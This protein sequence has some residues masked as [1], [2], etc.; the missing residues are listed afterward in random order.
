MFDA[1]SGESGR[2]FCSLTNF[3]T[4]FD[5]EPFT[6]NDQYTIVTRRAFDRE[7]EDAYD[8]TVTCRDAGQPPLSGSATLQVRV[9]D[10]NDNFPTFDSSQY[11][12]TINENNRPGDVIV[13][14]H[15][16]DADDGI[17]AR[18]TYSIDDVIMRAFVVVDADSGDVTARNPL[19]R[20]A[21]SGLNFEV[22]ATDGGSPSRTTHTL[23]KVTIRDVNDE[24]PTFNQTTFAMSVAENEPALTPVGHVFARDLD[25]EPNAQFEY[26]LEVPVAWDV[27]RINRTSGL[28]QT[29][30]ELDREERAQ[31][32]L[33]VTARDLLDR[34]LVTSATVVIDVIDRN[35]NSPLMLFP[36][37]Q[38]RSVTV[39]SLLPVGGSVTRVEAID[40][41]DLDN[42]RLEF[43]FS[44]SVSQRARDVF[45]VD[46]V[47][48]EV[49][50]R[51]S[52][53]SFDGVAF[54]LEVE[55]I[56]H[57]SPRRSDT[58]ELIVTIDRNAP[59]TAPGNQPTDDVTSEASAD[60]SN[61]RAIVAVAVVSATIV[62]ALV[63]VIVVIKVRDQTPPCLAC[64]RRNDKPKKAIQSLAQAQR[65]KFDGVDNHVMTMETQHDPT[66][67][68]VR[69][70]CISNTVQHIHLEDLHVV[71]FL[72]ISGPGSDL[73]A[74]T[75]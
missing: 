13:R 14:V 63:V 20:E 5:L 57:G 60:V 22:S 27:F 34:T 72:L 16:S 4:E 47:T 59:L 69:E 49:R 67:M 9:G 36:S 23:V 17:N 44:D 3:Q 30:A 40:A 64:L 61:L 1:D 28:I 62:V 48:G 19:N 37:A 66:S 33:T 12:V 18:V 8:V 15:A 2:T 45:E 46:D 10:D 65:N 50:A 38:N 39:S 29:T 56:D 32:E 7:D 43:R 11:D 52:L 54:A 26:A 75:S 55:V 68:Q 21:M 53:R 70:A 42:A 35:D 58:G 51:V 6:G 25:T 31:F 41:D 71:K 74:L 73:A 24:A